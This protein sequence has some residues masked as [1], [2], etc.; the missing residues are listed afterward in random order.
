MSSVQ[1]LKGLQRIRCEAQLRAELVRILNPEAGEDCSSVARMLEAMYNETALPAAASTPNSA[2]SHC[3]RF[4]QKVRGIGNNGAPEKKDDEEECV[5]SSDEMVTLFRC[6]HRYTSVD[7]LAALERGIHALAQAADNAEKE[8]SKTVAPAGQPN[9]PG[10]VPLAPEDKFRLLQI[11]RNVDDGAP[12]I[13]DGTENE[14]GGEVELNEQDPAFLRGLRFRRPAF[15]S[16]RQNVY[17][18]SRQVTQHGFGAPSAAAATGPQF[19]SELAEDEPSSMKRAAIRQ[20]Q[21]IREQRDLD[22]RRRQSAATNAPLPLLGD[23]EVTRSENVRD[24]RRTDM[25]EPVEERGVRSPEDLPTVVPPWLRGGR[26]QQEQEIVTFGPRSRALSIEEHRRNLPIAKKKNEILDTI[27]SHTTTVLVA[28]T[29]SGKTTQIPQYLVERG[30]HK[31]GIIG[32]TQPRKV[33]AVSIAERVAMEYGCRLG[34]EVGYCVRF[35]DETSKVTIIKYMTDG[36]LLREALLDD[37]FAKYSVIILD[38]AHDRSLNTDVLFGLMK[39]AVRKRPSLKLVVTSAT[40]DINHFCTFF[41][42]API[43]VDG[44]TFPVEVRYESDPIEDYLDCAL[45]RVMEIHLTQPPGDILVFLTGQD[46]IEMGAQRLFHWIE[47]MPELP[48][49]IILPVYAALPQ[50][51]QT[52]VFDKTPEGSRKVVLATNIAETSIT[53]DDLY[54]VIDT[55][56]CKQNMFDAKTGVE[57]LSVVPISKQQANQRKG[58]AGRTGPGLCYR[59][60]TEQQF[61]QELQETTVPDIQRVNLCNVVLQLKAVGVADL[62]SFDFLDPPPKETLFNALEKLFFLGALDND[63][64]L[65]NLGRR[66]SEL[67]IEPSESKTLLTAVDLKCAPTVLTVVSMLSVPNIFYRTREKQE[68]ADRMRRLFFQSEGDQLTLVAVYD[69]WLAASK[70]EQWARAHFIN[71]RGLNEAHDLRTQLEGIL[72]R[73][74][75]VDADVQAQRDF[76]AVRKAIT[77]GYFFHAAKRT[78][79]GKY[80]TLTDRREVCI[81]PS[82]TLAFANPRYVIYHELAMTT[83]E[84]MRDVMVINPSWLVELAPAFYSRPKEGRLTREQMTQ[85]LEPTLRRWEKGNDW[86]ISKLRRKR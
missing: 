28:E 20:R 39:A 25:D 42:A 1:T 50:E 80:L 33:A 67:P 34:E 23:V 51:V 8:G 76:I 66:M 74:A 29:G 83:R 62:L 14:E 77:A 38:E 86:R 79:D 30:Y 18:T 72:M 17:R 32:C 9:L 12:P 21:L 2:E 13:F 81:H 73:R 11:A 47:K 31:K 55:G 15:I 36:M 46:E 56:F 45:R 59:L 58:R 54:F 40:L 49:L 24:V 82:S 63:G 10:V 75:H 6:I 26:S 85:R 41:E 5:F 16:Q 44:R 22:K 48:P 37:T 69:A 71:F 70:S 52:K 57:K 53:I 43:T 35:R 61:E 27:D 60:Y 65:T 4:I 78:P 84:Y 7:L 64:T 3:E 68:E 19:V